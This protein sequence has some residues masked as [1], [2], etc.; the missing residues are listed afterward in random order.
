VEPGEGDGGFELLLRAPDFDD[1]TV[2][3]YPD[4]PAF[5]FRLPDPTKLSAALSAGFADVSVI[6]TR[7]YSTTPLP[8][9]QVKAGARVQIVSS[10]TKVVRPFTDHLEFWPGD[11]LQALRLELVGAGTATVSLLVPSGFNLPSGRQDL[12]VTVR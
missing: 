8:M 4:N 2:R 11:S 9:G 7:S 3:I 6:A 5:T 12:V 1:R 10:D